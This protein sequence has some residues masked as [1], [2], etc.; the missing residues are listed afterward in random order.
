M[1][2]CNT[3]L[4]YINMVKQWYDVVWPGPVI[5]RIHFETWNILWICHSIKHLVVC[6]LGCRTWTSGNYNKLS[7]QICRSQATR[8][9]R[10]TTNVAE[11]SEWTCALIQGKGLSIAG[12]GKSQET[13][14]HLNSEKASHWE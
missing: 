5:Y 1:Q 4:K 13:T 6:I 12:C 8:N 11:R 10:A 7:Q 9:F 14:D 2:Y 3:G